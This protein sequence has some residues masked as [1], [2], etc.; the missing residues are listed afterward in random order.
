[1]K[2]EPEDDMERDRRRPMVRLLAGV[3][4]RPETLDAHQL[5]GCKECLQSAGLE[6]VE[7]LDPN[8][9]TYKSMLV[10]WFSKTARTAD[11]GSRRDALAETPPRQFARSS[12]DRQEEQE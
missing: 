8:T 11:I 4:I 2:N 9:H 10:N 6:R 5:C 12:Q 3:H 7:V 1:M